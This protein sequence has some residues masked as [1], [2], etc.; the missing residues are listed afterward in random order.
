VRRSDSELASRGAVT[1]HEHAPVRA[2][3]SR[4]AFLVASGVGFAGLDLPALLQSA[5]PR[6]KA[7]PA[8]KARSAIL[9]W[10]SGGASHLDTWATWPTASGTSDKVAAYPADRPV[11]PE[12]LARTVYHALGLHDLEA[13]D[14]EGRPFN[15]LPDGKALRELF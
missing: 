7:R 14:R 11:Y 6:A 10:L 5:L 8:G 12:D 1:L 15:L 3:L 13:I 2:A 4:R 9:S